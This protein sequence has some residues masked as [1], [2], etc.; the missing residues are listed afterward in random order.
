LPPATAERIATLVA[1]GRLRVRAARLRAASVMKR[2][3]AV[4]THERRG[5]GTAHY[6]WI[7]NCTGPSFTKQTCRGL[8]R[9]LLQSGLLIADP[10]ALG[11]VTTA[12]GRAFGAHGP[13]PGLHVLGPAC[14]SQ[15]WEHTAVPELREQARALAVTLRSDQRAT[16]VLR[17]R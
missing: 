5:D 9:R 7:V 17:Q 14:R 13:I 1:D 6:D 10:L 4:T 12:D 3:I 11:F 2:G 8:E 15:R 16:P